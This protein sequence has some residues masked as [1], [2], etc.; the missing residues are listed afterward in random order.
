MSVIL[1]SLFSLFCIVLSVFR[2]DMGEFSFT[3]KYV[4]VIF[5]SLAVIIFFTIKKDFALLPLGILPLFPLTA[6]I[7]YGTFATPLFTLSAS[8]SP[9]VVLSGISATMGENK[10][11][12]GYAQKLVHNPAVFIIITVFILHTVLPI[13]SLP[14][15]FRDSYI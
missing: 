4:P 7:L 10:K 3:K 12:E 11:I 1:N 8:V 15:S 2:S 6:G 13:F 5:L 14:G 9:F